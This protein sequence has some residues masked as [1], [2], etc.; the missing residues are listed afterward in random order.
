MQPHFAIVH[1]IDRI[2]R[3]FEP[4]ANEV[5][6]FFVV[7]ENKDA[8]SWRTIRIMVYG[9]SDIK[10]IL[11]QHGGASGLRQNTRVIGTAG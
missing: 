8:H 9:R 2:A 1:Y 6:D 5:R 11:G 7:F 4:L 3:L 10:S